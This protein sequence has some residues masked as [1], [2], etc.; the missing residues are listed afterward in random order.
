MEKV[1]DEIPSDNDK[2]DSKLSEFKEAEERAL[3]SPKAKKLKAM[4]SKTE[5]T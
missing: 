2:K 4:D 5:V 3:S 1:K